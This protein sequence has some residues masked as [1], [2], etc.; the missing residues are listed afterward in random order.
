MSE[1]NRQNQQSGESTNA[2]D[3]Q[4]PAPG[5]P[6][7][8]VARPD[9]PILRPGEGLQETPEPQQAPQPQQVTERTETYDPSNADYVI[10][11]QQELDHALR[12]GQLPVESLQGVPEV[13]DAISRSALV[14]FLV[15]GA[16]CALIVYAA[17]RREQAAAPAPSSE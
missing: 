15:G 10:R 16:A 8:P 9:V 3:R 7:Q 11:R 13:S 17:T 12:T 1:R 4:G 2:A 5:A 6:G 14:G